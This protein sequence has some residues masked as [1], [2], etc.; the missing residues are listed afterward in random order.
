MN[1]PAPSP[2]AARLQR[3][4]GYLE[5]D[6]TNPLLLADACE[7]A[8]SC[9]QHEQAEGYI[10]T[11][12]QLAL[13]RGEWTFR[14]ARLCIAR[15]ALAEAAQL[16]EQ[17]RAESG[18]HPVL[19][20]DLAHVRL[21]QG[22]AQA[23]FVLLQPWMQV[24]DTAAQWPAHHREAMQSL[25]L[26]ACHR[27]GLLEEASAWVQEEREAGMLQP[28]A[29][30]VASLVALDLQD[31]PAAR[32]LA[33]A[34][35]AADPAQL[36]AL[37]ARGTIA[38][39]EGDTRAARH[40]LQAALKR[41]PEDG[42][43]WS[44]LGFASMME[45]DFAAAREQLARAVQAMPDHVETWH[46]LAWAQLLRGNADGAA[47]AL[48]SALALDAE[49]AETHGALAI[50]LG[51]AGEQDAAQRHLEAAARLDPDSATLLCA[52]ALRGGAPA[53][54]QALEAMLREVLVRWRP[55][56]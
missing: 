46:A 15:R 24:P 3:L 25:W 5:Q 22:D 35:L 17:L 31:L 18:E 21:L 50:V 54:R 49:D 42:R 56:P 23:A 8:I 10:A 30:G 32:I 26:R 53:D 13:D 34:A 40:W 44:A 47:A 11:A 37:V 14:R 29:S 41:H 12:Q 38:L 52:Q 43:T 51:L 28:A 45:S 27:V 4:C 16:L 55:R 20:H 39:A 36:E 7:A 6:P 9:G 19:A 48:R 33:D 2:A 1:T